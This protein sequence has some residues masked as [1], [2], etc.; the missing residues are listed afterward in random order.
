[1]KTIVSEDVFFS[2]TIQAYEHLYDQE[3]INRNDIDNKLSSRLTI[4]TAEVTLVGYL[5][6][7]NLIY[8]AGVLIRFDTV[9]AFLLVFQIVFFYRTFFRLKKNYQ[10]IAIEEIRMFHLFCAEEK[11]CVDRDL[12]Y[13]IVSDNEVE[14]LT[15][16]RDSYLRC[17]Y[18]DMM[19]NL[20][21][22][23][24]LIVFDNLTLISL[25]ML[26]INGVLSYF[27]GGVQ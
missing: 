27:N 26:I 7:A 9:F 12:R 22:G 17:A 5:I 25:V 13:R 11:T 14:L 21:R 4:L 18:Y 20:K 19:T 16:L 24:S 15:Y 6:K 2:E 8:D 1:M 10:E 3:R 23:S